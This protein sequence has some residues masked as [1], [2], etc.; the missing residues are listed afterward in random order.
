M[1]L[2]T[3]LKRFLIIRRLG[4]MSRFV[5][6]PF[7][8]WTSDYR[9]AKVV[10]VRSGDTLMVITRFPTDYHLFTIRLSGCE[11][12]GLDKGK[13]L[14]EMR[15]M[16]LNRI[17][18]LKMEGMDELGRIRGTLKETLKSQ[19]TINHKLIEMGYAISTY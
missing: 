10:E 4:K 1:E 5:V 18:F 16:W 14:R 19:R 9:P 15:S 11:A 17:V 3:K 7:E 6:E 13:V 2:L 12:H 8:F